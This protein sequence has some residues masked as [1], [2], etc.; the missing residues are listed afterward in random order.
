M[1]KIYVFVIVIVLLIVGFFAWEKL[2]REPQTREEAVRQA[3]EYKPDTACIQVS[4]PAV[5]TTTGARYT[6]P[7]GC[8]A[9]GWEREL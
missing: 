6:F 7:T 4:T 9:P 1:K 8:L 2:R 3:Q 5:H